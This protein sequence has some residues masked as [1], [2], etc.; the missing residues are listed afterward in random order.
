M[1]YTRTARTREIGIIG[2]VVIEACEPRIGMV[3]SCRDIADDLT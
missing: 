1:E 2:L 3:L